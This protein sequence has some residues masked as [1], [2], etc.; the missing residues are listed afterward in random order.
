MK[1]TLPLT[2]KLVA[3]ISM[4]V[5]WTMAAALRTAS[6][7]MDLTC[8]NAAKDIMPPTPSKYMNFIFLLH[9]IGHCLICNN[10]R[11]SAAFIISTMKHADMINRCSNMLSLRP[12]SHKCVFVWKRILFD[13]FWP[14]VL[15]NI[16]CLETDALLNE[17]ESIRKHSQKWRKLKMQVQRFCVSGR[18]RSLSK[19]MTLDYVIASCNL[20]SSFPSQIQNKYGG[21]AN[22]YAFVCCWLV[23]SLV[24][25][26]ISRYLPFRW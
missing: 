8:V 18:K 15:T 5:R 19:T 7:W 4:N 14:S 2:M 1:V 10:M 22:G 6:T 12:H 16:K 23:L 3:R 24:W 25:S 17:N 21:R 9:L 13:A 11:C 26:L 20:F